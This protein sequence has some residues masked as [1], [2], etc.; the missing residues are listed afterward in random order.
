MQYFPIIHTFIC[1][2]PWFLMLKSNF[3]LCY[4]IFLPYLGLRVFTT[5]W[6]IKVTINHVHWLF[7]NYPW[8]VNMVL[9]PTAESCLSSLFSPSILYSQRRSCD[10]GKI[11]SQ[12]VSHWCAP[13]WIQL[14]RPLNDLDSIRDNSKKWSQVNVTIL[15]QSFSVSEISQ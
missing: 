7:N 15:S 10:L 13:F 14:L 4:L 8:N 12:Y 6:E 2:F 3:R 9:N 5:Q 1:P 11:S